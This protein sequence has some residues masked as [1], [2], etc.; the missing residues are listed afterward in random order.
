MDSSLDAYLGGWESPDDILQELV[1]VP[2]P[3]NSL[4]DAIDLSLS[5]PLNISNVPST[6]EKTLLPSPAGTPV[7]IFSSTEITMWKNHK[8]LL[9]SSEDLSKFV[10]QSIGYFTQPFHNRSMFYVARAHGALLYFQIY[11]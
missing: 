5:S 11:F 8:Y 9:P 4:V 3:Q 10:N 2:Q 1:A 7:L 6:P